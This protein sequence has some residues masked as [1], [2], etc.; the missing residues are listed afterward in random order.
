MKIVKLSHPLAN[1]RIQIRMKNAAEVD[2]RELVENVQPSVTPFL[3]DMFRPQLTTPPEPNDVVDERCADELALPYR[4]RVLKVVSANAVEILDL[5]NSS[6][7]TVRLDNMFNDVKLIDL[8]MN[9]SL[10]APLLENHDK[11]LNEA[12]G[13][14]KFKRERSS[15]SSR[16]RRRPN[17][18]WSS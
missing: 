8:S 17:S 3:F 15:E 16:S 11:K 4:A 2:G 14:G 12:D 5:D 10:G 1:E 18:I 9:R 13:A 6:I 7:K